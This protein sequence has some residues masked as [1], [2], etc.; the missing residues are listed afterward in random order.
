MAQALGG[1]AGGR[2]RG[3]RAGT[4]RC[5]WL[6]KLAQPACAVFHIPA[7]DVS[8][9][10]PTPDFVPCRRQS[11]QTPSSDSRYDLYDLLLPDL[12]PPLNAQHGETPLGLVGELVLIIPPVIHLLSSEL[13]TQSAKCTRRTARTSSFCG[14]SLSRWLRRFWRLR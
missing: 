5:S 2:V 10:E 9:L 7:V 8:S 11:S 13:W 1:S 6:Y 14:F 12:L 4:C 3:A